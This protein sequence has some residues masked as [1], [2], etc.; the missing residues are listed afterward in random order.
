M[1]VREPA[2]RVCIV[3]KQG[4]SFFPSPIAEGMRR[5]ANVRLTGATDADK[6][7]QRVATAVQS[8]LKSRPG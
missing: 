8:A 7:V 2:G 1:R 6:V 5:G 4:F 3:N